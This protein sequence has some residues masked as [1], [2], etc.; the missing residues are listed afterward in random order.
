MACAPCRS[1]A[2]YEGLNTRLAA[3]SQTLRCRPLSRK[4]RAM[5]RVSESTTTVATRLALAQ[6]GLLDHPVL[7]SGA[8][9]R[10]WILHQ[11]HGPHQR[12]WR[13]AQ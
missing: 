12:L 3:P 2:V 13:H 4:D 6:A 5:G 1:G 7:T 8:Q 11:Q 10:L 9:D